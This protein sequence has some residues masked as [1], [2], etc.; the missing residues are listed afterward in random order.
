MPL[1]HLLSRFREAVCSY[2][3]GQKA[4]LSAYEPLAIDSCAIGGR[5]VQSVYAP[6]DHV[7]TS[8]RIA[9]VGM[10]PGHHQALKAIEVAQHELNRGATLENAA[11]AAKVH[12]SFSGEPMRTN[13]V[14]MLDQ[15]G[16]ARLLDLDSTAELW[17]AASHLAHFTSVLRYPVFVDG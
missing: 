3:P 13:L 12:A 1:P 8:A 9:I 17:G 11:R 15:I 6:F 7:N 2:Q 14:R 4:H 5:A 10:T 16:V